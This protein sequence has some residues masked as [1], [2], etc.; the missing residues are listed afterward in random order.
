MFGKYEI[1]KWNLPYYSEELVC[2][3]QGY[4]CLEISMVKSK[5]STRIFAKTS[6]VVTNERGWA[7]PFFSQKGE[8]KQRLMNIVAPVVCSHLKFTHE[9]FCL[10]LFLLDTKSWTMICKV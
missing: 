7:L 5:Q 9:F 6:R 10:G 2:C 4:L 3:V 8:Q 1:S